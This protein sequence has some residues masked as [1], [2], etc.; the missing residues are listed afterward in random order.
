M[1]TALSC[2]LATLGLIVNSVAVIIG[3]MLVAPLMGP[4]MGIALASVARRPGLYGRALLSLAAG[5]AL[6]VAFSTLLAFTARHLPFGALQVLP[7]EVDAR[8]HPS[9]FDLGIALVGGAAGAYSALRLKGAAALAGV[10]IATALMPPL[11]SVG[12]GIALNDGSLARGAGLLFLTNLVAITSA[13]LAV[14]AALG[15]RSNGFASTMLHTALGAAGLVII[16]AALVGL[17][18]RTVNDARSDERVRKVVSSQLEAVFPGSE[19]L[20]MDRKQAGDSLEIRVRVQ[21]PEGVSVEQVRTLQEN[22]ADDLRRGV[23][24][25]FVGVPTLKLDAV[26]PEASRTPAP[27]S[28]TPT[29]QATATATPSPTATSTP[30]PPTPTSAPTPP[31]AGNS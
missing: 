15:L 27:P 25:T 30:I 31:L 5:T 4:I 22:I 17:T 21:V 16:T 18:V 19:L 13:A 3:A 29:A 23:Q 1:L 12:I 10:A 26:Q 7:S 6:A 20:S 2:A 11:C 24:L 8:G 9:V 14:F 28:P